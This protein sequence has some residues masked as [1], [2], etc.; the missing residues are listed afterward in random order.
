MNS[1][2][3]RMPAQVCLA[4]DAGSRSVTAIQYG[5]PRPLGCWRAAAFSPF[6]ISVRLRG[7]VGRPPP[8]STTPPTHT[9]ACTELCMCVQKCMNN[10]RAR[11]RYA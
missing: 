9:C 10:E 1:C 2:M 7:Q 3:G 4:W 6:L 5:Q 11:M 8:L